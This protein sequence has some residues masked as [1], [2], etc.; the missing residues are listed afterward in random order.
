MTA[1]VSPAAAYISSTL[2]LRASTDSIAKFIQE[3]PDNLQR[4]NELQKQR[5]EAYLNWSNAASLLK[6]LPVPE[7]AEALGQIESTLWYR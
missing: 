7:M 1:P 2:A 6:T 3:D 4:L 5:E